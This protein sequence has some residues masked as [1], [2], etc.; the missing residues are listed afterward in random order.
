MAKVRKAGTGQLVETELQGTGLPESGAPQAAP[1]PVTP[2]GSAAAG[3]NQDVAKMSGTPQQKAPV[4]AEAVAPEQTLQT[5]Q[6]AQA[7]QPQA[8]PSAYQQA[9]DK[10]GTLKG[11][12]SYAD[13]LQ[14]II[15]TKLQ[16]VATATPLVKVSTSAL[17]AKYA[18]D[19]A[20]R[21]AV[22]TALTAYLANPKDPAALQAVT[23]AM[24]G[25]NL[26]QA[27]ALEQLKGPALGGLLEGSAETPAAFGEGLQPVTV[28]QMA[29]SKPGWDEAFLTQMAADLGA[30]LATVKT[31]SPDRLQAKI[32]G[33]VGAE[34]SQTE[35]L[36][37]ELASA[38][39]QRAQQ[40]RAE[41]AR[42]GVSGVQATEQEARALADS[43]EAQE[44][45]LINGQPVNIQALLADDKVSDL[46]RNAVG[47]PEALKALKDNLVTAALGA[48][49][50]THMASLAST[51]ADTA[52]QTTSLAAAQG[53]L[54]DK[55][56]DVPPALLKQL[57]YEPDAVLT[58]AQVTELEAKVA[59]SPLV[60]ALT[61]N[62]KLASDYEANPELV[63]A[64]LQAGTSAA[65]VPTLLADNAKL[66]SLT[67]T[68]RE[69]MATL[70]L[71]TT[72]LV[73]DPAL[74]KSLLS[75]YALLTKYGKGASAVFGSEMS[76]KT[77]RILRNPEALAEVLQTAELMEQYATDPAFQ[78]L[79][80]ASSWV[81][82]TDDLAVLKAQTVKVRAMKEAYGAAEG[83]LTPL[84]GAPQLQELIQAGIIDTTAELAALAGKNGPQLLHD[85]M[86][87]HTDR[88]LLKALHGA[89]TSED[90]LGN[91]AKM[92]FGPE[93]TGGALLEALDNANQAL[94]SKAAKAW[95]KSLN[96]MDVNHDGLVNRGDF[97]GAHLD[98]DPMQNWR[99]AMTDWAQSP[100]EVLAGKVNP[101]RALRTQ[102]LGLVN[103]LGDDG[104]AVENW[105]QRAANDLKDLTNAQ[106]RTDR[107]NAKAAKADTTVASDTWVNSGP[108]KDLPGGIKDQPQDHV[109]TYQ[110][111][112]TEVIESR[113]LKVYPKTT[114]YG[115]DK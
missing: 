68:E 82:K 34:M 16:Q 66:A 43:L 104:W 28:A 114:R 76:S 99:T 2:A 107:A 69:W 32:Q 12:G 45:I 94:P 93:A 61:A 59:G 55:F 70:G 108:A 65:D 5:A 39:P 67:D 80:G 89:K 100:D 9:Q 84:G 54:A 58:P 95:L 112:R 53:T 72:K 81:P 97:M 90:V 62:P 44:E 63:T 105:G 74:A 40:I 35:A 75:T 96:F 26:T 29:A 101:F 87:A 36:Q 7:G 110:S 50:E 109:I 98:D 52:E 57:G 27:A 77:R 1:T 79:V 3:A 23:Q 37:A 64:L 18:G 48:W 111:G 20:K 41:L 33:L 92:V 8:D 4:L 102:E 60:Q 6:R 47:S 13:R 17:D 73:T 11:Y 83:K 31:W 51:V 21:A 106:R 56:K 113:V 86:V 42:L 103:Q 85:A 115:E 91:V 38:S 15:Q 78:R 71:D 46:I 19:P 14:A 10:L 24:A 25:P 22:Q 88:K 49:V 30:D